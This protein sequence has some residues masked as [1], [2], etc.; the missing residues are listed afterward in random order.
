MWVCICVPV[1]HQVWLEPFEDVLAIVVIRED[2]RD[3]R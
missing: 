2:S 3:L 1:S